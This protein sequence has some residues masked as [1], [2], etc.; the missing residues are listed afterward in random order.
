[1]R[2]PDV[3][4]RMGNLLSGPFFQPLWESLHKL[5]LHRMNYGR[6]VTV[7]GS[8]EK[9]VLAYLG[10]MH[11]D[12]SGLTLFDVGANSGLYTTEMVLT[13]GDRADIFSFEPNGAAFAQL[14]GNLRGN[15]RVHCFNLGLSDQAEKALLFAPEEA[16]GTAS[17]YHRHLDHCHIVMNP[18]GE[19]SL[20]TLD[21]FCAS[22]G[23]GEIDF[24]KIDVEGHELKVLKGASN[25]IRS[26]RVK[27]IQFEFGDCNIDSK[28]Y[29]KDFFELLDPFY[30]MYRIL[31]RGLRR[32]RSYDER[33]EV[34][35]GT[36]YLALLKGA[37][38]PSPEGN[39]GATKA[40][41]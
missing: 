6:G 15:P 19:V 39:P 5:S 38:R 3:K 25:M 16:S 37:V 7:E 2:K 27:A 23:I 22:A 31:R 30:E 21:R 14:S 36:N 10:R 20:E 9:W 12:K 35:K 41:R 13:F 29:F 32:I 11:R 1:M 26:G 24:L 28:T 8:G 33:Y 40:Y 4:R 34:F 17:L 18:V